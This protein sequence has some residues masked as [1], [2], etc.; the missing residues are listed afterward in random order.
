MTNNGPSTWVDRFDTIAVFSGALVPIGIAVGNAGYEA[1]I[2]MTGLCWIIRSILAKSNPIPALVKHPL[3][4]G[5]LALYGCILVSLLWNGPG[6]KGWA[7]DVVLIRHLLFFA[8]FIDISRRRNV[9]RPLIIGLGAGVLWA[10]LNALLA[11]SIGH[12]LIGK[13]IARYDNKLKEGERIASFAAYAGPFFLAWGLLAKDLLLKRRA[14]FFG[15]GGIACIMLVVFHIRT[16]QVGAIFGILMAGTLYLY[17]ALPRKLVMVLFLL[18]GLFMGVGVKYTN[19]DNLDG[20]D[21]RINLDSM[22]DRVNIW[23]V[24]WVMWK[25]NPVFGVSVSGWKDAYKKTVASFPPYVW[26]DGRVIRDAEAMHCHNLFLQILSSLGIVGILCF[27][28][29]FVN[30]IRSTL[31]SGMS[32]WRSGLPI[33]PAIFL[34]IGLTGWNFFGSQYLPIFTYFL[35][36][37]A[38]PYGGKQSVV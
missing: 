35:S 10:A 9:I 11:Y 15:I 26:P 12:D 24:S 32:G 36:L 4:Q 17:R 13:S 28:W 38:I 8:A 21:D 22:Y 18:L 30:I 31:S 23:K 20:I 29:F 25:D 34:V 7:H 37:T 1:M 3:L 33:W 27:C 2:S 19:F 5:W 6:S 14:V 16:A